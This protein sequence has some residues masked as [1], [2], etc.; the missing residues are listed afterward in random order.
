MVDAVGVSERGLTHVEGVECLGHKRANV[1]RLAKVVPAND[2]GKGWGR[3][4]LLDSRHVQDLHPAV[5]P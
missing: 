2:L 5:E 3:K 4:I 1:V